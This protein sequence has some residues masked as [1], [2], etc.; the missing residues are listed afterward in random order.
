MLP[1]CTRPG[2]SSSVS[3]S[4][5]TVALF[6]IADVPVHTTLYRRIRVLNMTGESA[7][8]VHSWDG[9]RVVCIARE[10]PLKSPVNQRVRRANVQLAVS[11]RPVG[12]GGGD[13]RHAGV[14]KNLHRA[15]HLRHT[16]VVK[17]LG[18]A[19]TAA[20]K[21]GTAHAGGGVGGGASAERGTRGQVARLI[22]ELG[23]A[24]AA[25]LGGRLGLTPAAIRRHLENLIADG[26]IEMRTARSY[27]NRGRGRPAK[28]FVLTDAGRAAFEH[29]YDDLA[30]SALRFLEQAGGPEAVAEF[31]RRQVSGARAA[32]RDRAGRGGRDPARRVQALAEALSAD[33]YAAPPGQRRRSDPPTRRQ[34]GAALPAPLP[35]RARR[36]RVPA[37]VRG[38]DRGVR[39]PARRPGPAPRDDRPRRRHLHDARAMHRHRQ[40]RR[41][42]TSPEGSHR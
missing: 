11:R 9:A 5:Q 25:T 10:G 15:S 22:L 21:G 16:G 4:P 20:A 17:S 36:R 26:M 29:T 14:G 1:S 38:R 40:R 42:D 23:P 30:T 7:C 24:T 8:D 34:R 6:P 2:A 35:G 12:G 31:A 41:N 3:R 13:L 27:G 39:P 19:A 28:V 37:A 18:A 33:G 32:L